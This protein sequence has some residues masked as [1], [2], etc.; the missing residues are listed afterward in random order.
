[1]ATTKKR[2]TIRQ[3]VD[4]DPFAPAWSGPVERR[5]PALVR[6]QSIHLTWLCAGCRTFTMYGSYLTGRCNFCQTPRPLE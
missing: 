6:Q 3:F 2:R 5:E 1:M 4:V